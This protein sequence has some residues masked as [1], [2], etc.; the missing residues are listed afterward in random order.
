MAGRAERTRSPA[1]GATE[2]TRDG[3]AAIRPRSSVL[4][5][6]ICAGGAVE[7]AAR[8]PQ[9][10]ATL[11]ILRHNEFGARRPYGAGTRLR[12]C[13]RRRL[14]LPGAICSIRPK[15]IVPQNRKRGGL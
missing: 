13:W 6:G 8:S 15:L 9:Q 3:P 12:C 4:L 1:A 11:A 5:G 2:R 10:S 14:P 7:D